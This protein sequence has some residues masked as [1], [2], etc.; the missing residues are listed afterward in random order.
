MLVLVYLM[1]VGLVL[2]VDLGLGVRGSFFM[3]G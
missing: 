1:L 2:E 3:G